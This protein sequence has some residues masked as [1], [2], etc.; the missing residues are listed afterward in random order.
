M[1][2]APAFNQS[3]PFLVPKPEPRYSPIP[4]PFNHRNKCLPPL[5]DEVQQDEVFDVRI[6]NHCNLDDDVR[7]SVKYSDAERRVKW[8]GQ[9]ELAKGEHASPYSICSSG[10][11]RPFS[12]GSLYRNLTLP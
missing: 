8:I 4:W 2:M 3:S 11:C 12:F 9:Q 1:Q 10:P 7:V 6:V 5:P